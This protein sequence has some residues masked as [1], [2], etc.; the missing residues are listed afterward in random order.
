MKRTQI[1][2]EESQD[3]RLAARA[4]DTGRTKSDLIRDAIDRY[5]D[6]DDEAQA[7]ARFRDGLH[8]TAGIA[9][10]LPSG[11]SYVA[12]LRRTDR[13]RERLYQTELSKSANRAGC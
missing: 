13:A 8:G 7:M 5:F 4:A 2:L 12:G 1:Y 6:E 10:Y 9:P 3:R 11:D